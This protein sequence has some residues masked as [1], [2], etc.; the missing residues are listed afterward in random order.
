M[1]HAPLVDLP[2]TAS[3]CLSDNVAG[4]RHDGVVHEQ[5]NSSSRG[6]GAGAASGTVDTR[7][8]GQE[9]SSA[10]FPTVMEALVVSF[11]KRVRGVSFG[12]CRRQVRHDLL[13]RQK[14]PNTISIP[15]VC[16]S[17]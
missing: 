7:S 12:S 14:R 9:G 3:L 1:H 15:H 8:G 10:M 13:L 16:H 11:D 5:R 17:Q 4:A 6:G 2:I